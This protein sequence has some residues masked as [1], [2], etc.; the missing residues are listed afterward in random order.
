MLGVAAEGVDGVLERAAAS[1]VA[2]SVV[3]TAGGDRLVSDAFDVSLAQ[4]TDAWRHA[5]PRALGNVPI[6]M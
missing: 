5:I 1:G 6:V 4:A 3:G 2:A